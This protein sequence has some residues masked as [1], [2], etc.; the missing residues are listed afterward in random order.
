MTTWHDDFVC[1]NFQW[2]RLMRH[3]PCVPDW[4]IVTFKAPPASDLFSPTGRVT[5]VTGVV[6]THHM[7]HSQGSSQIAEDAQIGAGDAFGQALGVL[8]LACFPCFLHSAVIQVIQGQ[9][10][11]KRDPS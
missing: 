2:T 5:A 1:L 11:M 7:P 6:T 9:L 10:S 4:L 3:H 8:F